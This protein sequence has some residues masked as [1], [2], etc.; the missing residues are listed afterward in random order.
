MPDKVIS[1]RVPHD[2]DAMCRQIAQRTGHTAT[3]VRLTA[4]RKGLQSASDALCIASDA[5]LITLRTET[6]TPAK[7]CLK[8]KH[9]RRP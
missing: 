6:L 3:T 5:P 2:V 1:I 4:M 7:S 8:H 9:S